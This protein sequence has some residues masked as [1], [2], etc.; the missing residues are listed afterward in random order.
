MTAPSHKLQAFSDSTSILGWQVLEE[1]IPA[2]PIISEIAIS[3]IVIAVAIA[4][5]AHG[6]RP[7]IDAALCGRIGIL[8]A[9]DLE[10][11]IDK[12]LGSVHAQKSTI[13]F[14]HSSG[15]FTTS[16]QNSVSGQY[17]MS[18]MRAG[19]AIKHWDG[20]SSSLTGQINRWMTNRAAGFPH[21][22]LDRRI[23][24]D[25][26]AVIANVVGFSAIWESEFNFQNIRRENFYVGSETRRVDT[27]MRYRECLLVAQSQDYIA[28]SIPY[29]RCDSMQCSF[30]ATMAKNNE[31]DFNNLVTSLR[32]NPPKYKIT[33]VEKFSLPRFFLQTTVVLKSNLARLNL[34]LDKSLPNIGPGFEHLD[35]I[36]H[37]VT[38][39]VEGTGAM[40]AVTAGVAGNSGAEAHR[41]E[42]VFNR[43]FLFTVTTLDTNLVLLMGTYCPG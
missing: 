12:A 14:E 5:I 3:P 41:P 30:S 32:I 37:S 27:M 38:I 19:A 6:S 33:F 1:L 28:V 18:I 23:Y 20:G 16:W 9:R 22:S 13:T 25:W 36:V 15:F 31:G 29:R 35:E 39:D 7:E 10:D 40:S 42:L 21:V 17:I 8:D 34:P 26:R 4:M 43:P 2:G 11:I 24:P